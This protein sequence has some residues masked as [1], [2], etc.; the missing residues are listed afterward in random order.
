EAP[1][2]AAA[3]APA[4]APAGGGDATEVPLPALGES[5]TEGTVTRWLKEVGDD[6]AVDEPL[7]EVS[8]DKVATEIPSPVAGTLQEILVQEDET[9]EVGAVLALVGS[10]ASA[11]AAEPTPAAPDPAA[12][13][14]E[15]TPQTPAQ[16][17]P[18]EQ[19]PAQEAPAQ[20]APAQEAPAAP[21]QPAPAQQAPAA[22]SPGRTI[23]SYLTPLVRKLAAEKGVDVSEIQGTGV[24]GR[25]RKEDV[26]A[27]AEAKAA[28]APAAA[29][30][31]AAPAASSAP[32]APTKLEV[33]PLR[34]PTE[35]MSRL[36]R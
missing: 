29:P 9:V 5:V 13:S 34:G 31:A 18:A 26:L 7:L 10:G 23:G 15:P 35:K 20:E 36:R 30:A 19:A 14:P 2:P 22:A 27:A 33:S 4:E 16:E 8:T 28:P 12:D 21:A 6:V 24:G 3:S 25:I 11:P 32:A 17:A 1:A